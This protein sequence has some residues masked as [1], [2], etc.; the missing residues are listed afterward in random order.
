MP[1]PQGAWHTPPG[2]TSTAQ[3]SRTLHQARKRVRQ[4]LGWCPGRGGAGQGVWCHLRLGGPHSM[5]TVLVSWRPPQTQSHGRSTSDP[6]QVG[7]SQDCW[8]Q[9]GVGEETV[10]VACPV[11]TMGLPPLGSR[12]RC[13]GIAAFCTLRPVESSLKAWPG[14]PD[15]RPT[16]SMEGLEQCLGL[17]RSEARWTP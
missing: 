4:T 2:G 15:S 14:F 11:L 17:P 10:G 6:A 5:E 3:W 8:G 16:D 7:G 12:G 13:T 9:R 1:G